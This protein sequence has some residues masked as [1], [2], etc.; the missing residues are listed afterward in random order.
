MIHLITAIGDNAKN[1]YLEEQCISDFKS[2]MRTITS[3]R[4][5][6][7]STKFRSDLFYSADKP[8]NDSILKLWALYANTDLSD[9][10]RK[11]FITSSGDEK[12]LSKYF[13]S[14]NRLST[15]WYHYKLYKKAFYYTF[16]ND[17]QNPVARTVVQCDQCV[18]ELPDIKRTPIIDSSEKVNSKLT[19]DTFSIA[20]HLINNKTLSN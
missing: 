12:S 20:M 9:F 8:L 10:V 3:G 5:M 1:F 7:V 18:T 15:N 17:P 19:K 6:I 13:Q 14:I 16:I 4:V 11:N 2:L